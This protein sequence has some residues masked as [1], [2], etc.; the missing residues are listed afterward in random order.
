MILK[1]QFAMYVPKHCHCVPSSSR[2]RN[3]SLMNESQ[4]TIFTGSKI[5]YENCCESFFLF[6]SFPMVELWTLSSWL[7][8][9]CQLGQQLRGALVAAQWRADTAVTFCCSGGGPRQSWSSGFAPVSK[10][11]S[12]FPFFHSSPS[13]ISLLAS[14]DVKQQFLSLFLLFVLLHCVCYFFTLPPL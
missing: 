10:F 4:T 14:V 7:C 2:H 1:G 3:E 12:S 5:K 11:H 9:A 8:S 13:L 6:S